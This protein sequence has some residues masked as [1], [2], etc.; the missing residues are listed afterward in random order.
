MSDAAARIDDR[1]LREIARAL[2]DLRFGSVE[3]TVH[4]GQVVSLERRERTRLA[5]PGKPG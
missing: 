4:D 5:P 3:V 1:I 2:T